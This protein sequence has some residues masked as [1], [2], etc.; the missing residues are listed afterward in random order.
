MIHG[1]SGIFTSQNSKNALKI[2]DQIQKEIVKQSNLHRVEIFSGTP[3]V[4]DAASVND[5]VRYV[6]KE[7]GHIDILINN[8]GTF[9]PGG[10]LTEKEGQLQRLLDIN[11]L[12]AY[13]FSRA[14]APQMIKAKKGH[15]FN[16]TSVAGM[17]S[18][19]NGGS[20]SISKFAMMGLSKALREELKTAHVKVTNVI[21][22]AVLTDAWKGVKLPKDRLIQPEDIAEM[23][24]AT[25]LLSSGCV[26]EDLLIRPALGDL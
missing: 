20:Y 8:V 5:F 4:N 9:E 19:P 26:V 11:L 2:Q 3:K 12:S 13:H 1:Y 17:Q 14:V 16:I 24:Y 25:T 22:G 15:I 18:Y 6:Q 10:V 23:V 7:F 21:P